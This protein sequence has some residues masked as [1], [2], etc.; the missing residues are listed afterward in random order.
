M[1]REMIANLVDNAL[2]YTPEGG[3]VTLS[4]QRAPGVVRL[5]VLDDGPGIPPEERE[6]V[7]KRFYRILGS[8][9]TQGSGLGLSIVSEICHA[10]Q[11][12]ISLDSGPGG[13]GL[14]VEIS[15]KAD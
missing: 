2:R 12:T 15:L 1:L 11:G 13:Q 9:D 8:G 5:R 3:H 14:A 7:L 6:N 10:H 4:L